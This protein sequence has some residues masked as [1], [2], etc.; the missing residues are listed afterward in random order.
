MVGNSNRTCVGDY[1]WPGSFLSDATF[2]SSAIYK[3][4][5]D[6]PAIW[7]NIPSFEYKITYVPEDTSETN[8]K[9]EK[10]MSQ[11]RRMVHVLVVDPDLKVPDEQSV[12]H[13]SKEFVTSKTDEELKYDLNLK[14]MLEEHNV[15][16]GKVVD[17]AASEKRGK[18]I[19]LKKIKISNL[20]IHVY[21]TAKF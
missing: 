9:K 5:A 16:R 20:V 8:T 13:D 6:S 17:E 2:G 11:Q 1:P 21:E 15:V 10:K 7:N 19:F 12:L 3:L 14:T 4:P 18:D